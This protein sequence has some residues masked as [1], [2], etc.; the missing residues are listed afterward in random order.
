MNTIGELAFNGCS[1]AS[2]K[3]ESGNTKYDSRN[4][5]NAIIE[6]ATNTLITGCKNTVIPYS[7]TTIGKHAFSSCESLIIINIPNSI[8]TIGEGNFGG[9]SG[10]TSITIPESV[11]S[12]ESGAFGGCKSLAFVNYQCSPT[13]VANDVFINSKIK[14]MF[15]DCEKI[16]LGSSGVRVSSITKIVMSDKV[17]SIGAYSF[18]GCTSLTSITIPNSVTSIGHH[19][20]RKCKGL[21]SVILGKSIREI[22]DAFYESNNIKDIY[23]Y[24]EVVP[25]LGYDPSLNYNATLHVPASCIDLYKNGNHWKKFKNIVALTDNDPKPTGIINTIIDAKNKERYYDLRGHLV[26]EPSKGLYI[27]NG[28]KVLIK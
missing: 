12:I 20:F 23:C 25:S 5:C 22:D 13:S 1:L 26:T 6:T 11:T 27:I 4:S 18:S 2:I 8:T 28:K 14:E 16:N 10:L 15:F 7:V 21:T 19:A 17:K 3:V 24:A 9:C